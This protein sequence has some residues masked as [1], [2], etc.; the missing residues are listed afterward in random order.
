MNHVWHRPLVSPPPGPGNAPGRIFDPDGECL[1]RTALKSLQLR[2]L[3]ACT[4]R[5]I[6]KCPFYRQRMAAAGIR[7]DLILALEDLENIPFT[8]KADLQDN[9]PYGLF[10]TPLQQVVRLQASSGT[11]GRASVTGYTARDI[12]LW[13]ELVARALYAAGVGPADLV[14]NAYGY[15]LFTGGLG[16]HY[17]AE[18]LGASVAAFSSRWPAT[19]ASQSPPFAWDCRSSKTT[20]TATPRCCCFARRP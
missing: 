17:G 9:Y 15:G 3:Q 8:T 7:S 14:Q 11:S 16:Y 13:S 6:E 5:L 20:M 18:R 12:T 10:A 4:A 2:R 19:C 1:S